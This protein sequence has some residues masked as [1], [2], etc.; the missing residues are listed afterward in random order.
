MNASMIVIVYI[1]MQFVIL[2]LAYNRKHFLE[3]A[4]VRW[5][6]KF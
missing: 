6:S 2:V 5:F 4:S 3:Q 1:L